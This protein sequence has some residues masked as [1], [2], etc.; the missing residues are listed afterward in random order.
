[1]ALAVD[2]I[3]RRDP[4]NSQEDLSEAVLAVYI[5]AKDVLAALH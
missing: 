2:V 4:S 1:M 5:T 3:N